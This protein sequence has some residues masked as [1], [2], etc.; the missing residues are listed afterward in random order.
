MIISLVCITEKS[1]VS[2]VKSGS[3]K[4]YRY[5]KEDYSRRKELHE[6]RQEEKRRLR[7]ERAF[8]GVD[9]AATVLSKNSGFG[10]IAGAIWALRC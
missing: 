10:G 5:A 6:E 3:G 9:L 1:F 8:K 7:E 4:A 2:A